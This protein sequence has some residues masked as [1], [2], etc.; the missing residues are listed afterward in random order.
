MLG[1]LPLRHR[2]WLAAAVVV[3]GLV[4]GLWTGLVP[5]VPY[6]LLT[7]FLLG[8]AGS[9]LAAGMILRSHHRFT[10]EPGPHS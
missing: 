1:P 7:G 9:V 10:G 4:M 3:T 5:A 2:I 6:S 8:A